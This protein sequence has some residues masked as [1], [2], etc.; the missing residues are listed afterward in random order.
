MKEMAVLGIMSGTSI[1]AVDYALCGV[2]KES[3]RLRVFWTAQYPHVLRTK[4]HQAA[5]GNLSSH[6]LAQLHH[7][8]G[9][10]FAT[11]AT[12]GKIRPQLAGLHGQ[13]IYHQPEKP[14]PATF[15]LGEPAYMVEALRM[16]VVNNFRAAD[17]AAGGQGAPLA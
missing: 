11:H 13:T 8:A 10:F 1:D 6:A 5:A 9:R 2:T 14:H 12:R 17:L 4:L 3:I 7:D 16:P 15:Q